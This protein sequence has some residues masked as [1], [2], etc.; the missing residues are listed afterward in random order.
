MYVVWGLVVL[1][2]PKTKRWRVCV[3]VFVVVVLRSEEV[4]EDAKP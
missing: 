4:N 3:C 1:V 2:G